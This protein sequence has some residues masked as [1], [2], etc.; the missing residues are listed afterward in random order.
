MT[1]L[2]A[3]REEEPNR[4]SAAVVR[5]NPHPAPSRQRVLI[6]MQGRWNSPDPMSGAVF[7][8]LVS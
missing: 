8:P 2:A 4:Y 1:D 5:V 6:E 7:Q 3:A